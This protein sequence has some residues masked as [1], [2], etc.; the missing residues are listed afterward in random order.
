MGLEEYHRKRDFERTP[1]PAGA[2]GRKARDPIFVVQKHN[3]SR[4]HYDVRIE[5]DGVLV[6]WAVPKGP[7]LDPKVKRLAVHVEDHPMDYAYFEG[8]IPR[9]NYG[10][11]QVIVWDRGTYRNVR[12]EPVARG[13]AAGHVSVWLEGTKL[14]GGWSLQRMDGTSWLLVKRNDELADPAVDIATERPESVLTGQTIEDLQREA[15]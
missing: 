3:A 4:L 11:G 2:R 9:D 7:S 15:G 10:A 6:S 1:E 8:V 5:V 12:D 13:I 14:R